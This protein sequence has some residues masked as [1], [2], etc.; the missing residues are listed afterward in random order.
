MNS[1]ETMKCTT[2]PEPSEELKRIACTLGVPPAV[3]LVITRIKEIEHDRDNWRD[4]AEKEAATS[5]ARVAMLNEIVHAL[6][7]DSDGAPP[8]DAVDAI[9]LL[10]EESS[11]QRRAIAAQLGCVATLES[12]LQ[13]IEVI[14]SQRSDHSNCHEIRY[15]RERERDYWQAVAEQRLECLRQVKAYASDPAAEGY[16]WGIVNQ[17]LDR[18]LGPPVNP[19]EAPN[20]NDVVPQV[21]PH[22][23]YLVASRDV[24]RYTPDG[25][26]KER[27]VF[28]FG[29][30][31]PVADVI[32]FCGRSYGGWAD[33]G[34]VVVSVW[35]SEPPEA[36]VTPSGR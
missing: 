26:T 29:E 28:V 24:H 30:E 27:D 34:M 12:L 3:G 25:G 22:P 16:P 18:V 15:Q 5:A 11:L 4:S 19:E 23:K 31:T 33:A 6:G 14:K 13:S 2:Q 8:M 17:I 1:G 20:P 10:K 21:R 7:L 9:T 35:D 36:A 32:G